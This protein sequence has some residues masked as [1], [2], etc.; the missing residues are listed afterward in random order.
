MALDI[1]DNRRINSPSLTLEYKNKKK[2]T[3]ITEPLSFW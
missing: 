1:G 3:N 2:S